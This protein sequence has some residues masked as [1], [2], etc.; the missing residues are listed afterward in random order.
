MH[1][2]YPIVVFSLIFFAGCAAPEPES[3][4][5]DHGTGTVLRADP[6]V[7][8]IVPQDYKIEK[9]HG[10]F[11]F[12][13]GP[14]WI[15]K[16][17][18]YLLFSDIPASAIYK[19]IPD[20]QVTDFLKPVF[21]GEYEEGRFVGSNGLLLDP[22]GN[23]LLC[24]HGGRRVSRMGEDGG[25][26]TVV[27]K[28]EG[29]GFNSPNDAVLHSDG[30]LYFTDPPY[31][32]TQQD[33]APAKELDFNG[34]YRYSAD[35]KLTLLN[36]DQSR[37]NG[38]GLSP[39]EKTLYVAN[40]GQSSKL[41]M[42]YPVNDDGTLG[43]G[44]VF[45]DASSEQ[46]DGAPDGLAL[47]TQGNIFATGPGGVWIFN[48]EGKHLGTIQPEEVP[49]NVTFGDADGKTLYMTARTGLYR[50]RLNAQGLVR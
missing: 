32:F 1:K 25:R 8:A 44:T 14:V 38:I 36:R 7:D 20:G 18:G 24:E 4:P 2:L 12:T 21:E 29:K 48:P 27:D 39:D 10:G 11:Q 46:A 9:L 23:L 31:G 50:V 40:S 28:Y 30:S 35:G 47:D 17:G 41:W 42:A 19:W 13:E 33:D 15:N 22:N 6:A 37:P 3:V 43:E 34:I 5:V 45:F 26:M 49:A 16:D